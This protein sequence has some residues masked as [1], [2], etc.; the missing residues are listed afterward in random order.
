[1][2]THNVDQNAFMQKESF[3]NGMK[4]LLSLYSI[5]KRTGQ[6]SSS[7]ITNEDKLILIT[8]KEFFRE[9]SLNINDDFSEFLSHNCQIQRSAIT[10]CIQ[11]QQYQVSFIFVVF[12]FQF[13]FT[14]LN[15]CLRSFLFFILR[16]FYS[17]FY[18]CVGVH[19]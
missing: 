6:T 7:I 12:F 15:F 18:N 5:E 4:E 13:T 2:T 16:L 19:N 3:R 1:M 11:C 10:Y 9:N 17:T 8:T 14:E